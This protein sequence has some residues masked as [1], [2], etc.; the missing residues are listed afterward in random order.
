MAKQLLSQA[1]CDGMEMDSLVD[2]STIL[3]EI[4]ITGKDKIVDNL[5]SLTVRLGWMS[6]KTTESMMVR[7]VQAQNALEERNEELRLERR[8]NRE[9][10]AQMKEQKKQIAKIQANMAKILAGMNAGKKKIEIEIDSEEPSEAQY[11]AESSSEDIMEVYSEKTLK[12][13][14]RAGPT[15]GGA[16]S[17]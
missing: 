12:E 9:Q 11:S 17:R 16:G 14:T 3:A 1:I 15:R 2:P 5:E 13:T 7:Y 8:L 6:S 4:E 10:K